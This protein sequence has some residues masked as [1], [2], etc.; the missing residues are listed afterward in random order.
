MNDTTKTDTTAE[1][2]IPV[3]CRF[4]RRELDALQFAT[5]A[6]ADATAVAC[7]VRVKMREDAKDAANAH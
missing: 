4:S 5:G 1:P 2:M 3:L 6:T 7:Y